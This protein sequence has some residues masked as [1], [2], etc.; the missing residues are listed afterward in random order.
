MSSIDIALLSLS[1]ST[2]ILFL[3]LLLQN[4][5]YSEQQMDSRFEGIHRELGQVWERMDDKIAHSERDIS[6]RIDALERALD[7]KNKV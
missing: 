5:R 1:A 7:S 6:D 4:R 3:M 2:A